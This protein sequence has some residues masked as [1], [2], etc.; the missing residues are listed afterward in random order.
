MWIPGTSTILGVVSW[1]ASDT[2][3]ACAVNSFWY[4]F[5][6]NR[7]QLRPAPAKPP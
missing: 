2:N 7:R 1:E 4:R 3:G 6:R 5:I